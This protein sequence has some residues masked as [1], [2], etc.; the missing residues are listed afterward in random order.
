MKYNQQM[1][2]LKKKPS[3]ALTKKLMNKVQNEWDSAINKKKLE[4]NIK[5]LDDID[6]NIK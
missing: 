4:F 6:V 1:E 2:A 5:T 3:N